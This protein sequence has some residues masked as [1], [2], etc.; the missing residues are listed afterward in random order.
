MASAETMLGLPIRDSEYLGIGQ[1]WEDDLY[2]SLRR[3]R[4][5]A[6]LVAIVAGGIAIV[7]LVCLALLVPLK[8]F[9]PY[10]VTVDKTTSQ[11]RER[12]RRSER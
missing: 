11:A 2:R 7:A 8:Q 12:E 10:V 4:S 5:L 9:E 3:S 1:R 6:C